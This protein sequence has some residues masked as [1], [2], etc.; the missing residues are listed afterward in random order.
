VCGCKRANA[1]C[2]ESGSDRGEVVEDSEEVEDGEEG[3]V[4]DE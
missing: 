2:G 4:E 1:C 3:T